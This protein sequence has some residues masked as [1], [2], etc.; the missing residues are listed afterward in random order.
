MGEWVEVHPYRGREGEWV[1]GIRDCEWI[2][3]KGDII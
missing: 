2:T 3:G 1:E